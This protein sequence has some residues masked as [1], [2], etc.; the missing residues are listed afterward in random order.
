MN[1]NCVQK[2]IVYRATATSDATEKQYIGCTD[3]FKPRYRNH[4]K[5]FNNIVYRN[6]TELSTYVWSQRAHGVNPQLRWS[7]IAKA[8]SYR[9]GDKQCSLCI[10]EKALIISYSSANGENLINTRIDLGRTCPHRVRAKLEFAPG[11]K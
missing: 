5:S 8:R 7:V 3:S 11:V 6:D 9:S 4:M 1:N 10:I 2:E